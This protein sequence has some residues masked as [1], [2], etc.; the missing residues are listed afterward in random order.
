MGTYLAPTTAPISCSW[1]C[2]KDRRPPSPEPGTDYAC[3][4]GTP[5]LCAAAGTV[6]VVDHNNCGGEGRRV[7]VDLADGRRV[8]YIHMSTISVKVSQ[9]VVRGTVL[10][11]SGASGNCQDWFYGPHVHVSLWERPGMP[12]KDTIDFAKQVGDLPKPPQPPKED[13]V[14]VTNVG[15]TFQPN[16]KFP[17]G[18]N[19][20]SPDNWLKKKD[21]NTRV[22]TGPNLHVSGTLS[23]T[24][25]GIPEGKTCQVRPCVSTQDSKGNWSDASLGSQEIVG[26]PGQVAAKVP[27]NCVLNKNQILRFK[28]YGV[29]A[30]VTVVEAVFRGAEFVNA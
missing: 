6:S 27:I 19:T 13:D 9:K 24:V 20:T 30:E 11:K 17:A 29:D 1:K 21:G 25:S 23:L 15:I 5:I 12:Y 14:K 8:S 10:G 3:A 22:I 26:N 16:Q 7:S 18:I 28:V 2:H 4:Y